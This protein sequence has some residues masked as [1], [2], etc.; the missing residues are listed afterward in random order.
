MA[1]KAE[2]EAELA[3][4]RAKAR[5][6]DVEPE[7]PAPEPETPGEAADASS[8]TWIEQVAERHGLDAAEIRPALERLAADLEDLPRKQPLLAL[9]LAFGLGFLA[10]RASK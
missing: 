7:R 6:A 4:L 1:T 5:T 9:G 2:L 8:D 3:A 10:G